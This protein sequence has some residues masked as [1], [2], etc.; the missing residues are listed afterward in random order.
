[1][2]YIYTFRG[3]NVLEN[4]IITVTNFKKLSRTISSTRVTKA[5]TVGWGLNCK[6]ARDCIK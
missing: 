1:M 4:A 6:Y 3:E 5:R 2:S